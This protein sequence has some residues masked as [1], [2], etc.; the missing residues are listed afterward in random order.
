MGLL[1][2][3]T[4]TDEKKGRSLLDWSFSSDTYSKFPSL[5]IGHIHNQS[6]GYNELE[7]KKI[8]SRICRSQNL[9]THNSNMVFQVIQ[10]TDLITLASTKI[11]EA[12]KPNGLSMIEPDFIDSHVNISLCNNKNT[13][14]D[15]G[16]QWLIRTVEEISKNI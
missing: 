6:I 1:S 9:T 13:M 14:K 11:I 8:D 5:I 3:Y 12:F 7:N 15:Q 10:K 4:S 2:S 16:V